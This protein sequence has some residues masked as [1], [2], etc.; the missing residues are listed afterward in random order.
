MHRRKLSRIRRIDSETAFAD[1]GNQCC[2]KSMLHQTVRPVAICGPGATTPAAARFRTPREIR[3]RAK[4]LPLAPQDDVHFLQSIVHIRRPPQQRPQKRMQPRLP[5]RDLL[6]QFLV[7]VQRVGIICIRHSFGPRTVNTARTWPMRLVCQR[8]SGCVK[9]WRS[10][11][12]GA[13][14][15]CSTRNR[16]LKYWV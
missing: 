12:Q 8:S 15:D 14:T 13:M 6:N 2:I 1:F 7:T 9:P 3:P 11:P 16:L 4:T 10:L 5:F